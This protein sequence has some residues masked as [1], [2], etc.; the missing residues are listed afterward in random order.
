[1]GGVKEYQFAIALQGSLVGAS[2][3]STTRAQVPG[4][5]SLMHLW[6]GNIM[7]RPG[8]FRAICK[9][10][11]LKVPYSKRAESKSPA[12]DKSNVFPFVLRSLL[13]KTHHTS[14]QTWMKLWG[15]ANLGNIKFAVN[16]LNR[17]GRELSTS[18]SPSAALCNMG[19]YWEQVPG[20]NSK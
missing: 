13:C 1:M 3:T 14:N 17:K 4:K 5:C 6:A 19:I 20:M 2:A 8:C 16:C 11:T 7:V 18:F 12:E 9:Q 10:I 15:L